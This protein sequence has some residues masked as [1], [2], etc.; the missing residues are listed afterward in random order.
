[1][2]QEFEGSQE[3]QNVLQETKSETLES[4]DMEEATSSKSV[5]SSTQRMPVHC[6]TV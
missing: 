3:Y 4:E 1:V 6:V 2:K 5:E